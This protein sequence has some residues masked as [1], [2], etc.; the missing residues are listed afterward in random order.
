[1]NLKEI[2]EKGEL[3][4]TNYNKVIYGGVK[5]IW[6]IMLIPVVIVGGIAIF[7]E[8]KSGMSI[9][10]EVIQREKLGEVMKDNSSRPGVF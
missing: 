8:K 9:P 2:A 6:I 10:D 7:Y 5:M 3:Y 4:C 1:L